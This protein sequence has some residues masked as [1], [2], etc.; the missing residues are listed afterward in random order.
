MGV[1][2]KFLLEIFSKIFLVEFETLCLCLCD[3]IWYMI[4]S[5]WHAPVMFCSGFVLARFFFAGA[6]WTGGGRGTEEILY[7]LHFCL[8]HLTRKQISRNWFQFLKGQ[9]SFLCCVSFK[10]DNRDFDDRGSVKFPRLH[11]SSKGKR[12]FPQTFNCQLWSLSL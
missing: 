9:C 7:I 2:W 11:L 8:V 6:G 1:S 5:I 4:C 10:V 3:H 12:C